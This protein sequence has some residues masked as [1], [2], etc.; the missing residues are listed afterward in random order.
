MQI[1]QGRPESPGAPAHALVQN[2]T[3]MAKLMYSPQAPNSGALSSRA[4]DT[5]MSPPRTSALSSSVRFKLLAPPVLV[6]ED[7]LLNS[8]PPNDVV[9]RLLC[10]CFLNLE[11]PLLCAGNVAL[12]VVAVLVVPQVLLLVLLAL[13]LLVVALSVR[14]VLTLLRLFDPLPVPLLPV[15]PH[16]VVVPPLLL[17][18]PVLLALPV[19]DI[20]LTLLAPPLHV[21][22]ISVPRATGDTGLFQRLADVPVHLAVKVLPVCPVRSVVI[23]LIV[24]VTLLLPLHVPVVV[25][26]ILAKLLS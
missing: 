17:M 5:Q 11:P 25:S 22:V 26:D 6:L 24:R 15:R 21:V 12:L 13:R 2:M 8:L 14:L 10:V 23:L 4:S 20:V 19:L 16:I 18:V 3:M 7:I 1:V 9:T